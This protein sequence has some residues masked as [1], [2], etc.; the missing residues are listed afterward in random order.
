[1]AS[2]GGVSMAKSEEEWRAILSPEQFRILRLKGTDPIPMGG[3]RRSP[4]RRAAATWATCS[5]VR[6]S[7][8]LP[9]NATAS[10]ASRSSLL[11]RRETSL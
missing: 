7:R 10:T 1:M 5:K 9:T 6:G 11:P 4:V 3:G 8:R 2:S